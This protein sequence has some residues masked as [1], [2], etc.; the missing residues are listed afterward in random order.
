MPS[1]L[2]LLHFLLC[3]LHLQQFNPQTNFKYLFGLF[4]LFCLF[5]SESGIQRES[6]REEEQSQG[7]AGPAQELKDAGAPRLRVMSGSNWEK[8]RDRTCESHREL[9]RRIE[10]LDDLLRFCDRIFQPLST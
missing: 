8:E 6:A 1:L 4:S 9:F 5:V 10:A 2:C 3:L 7:A